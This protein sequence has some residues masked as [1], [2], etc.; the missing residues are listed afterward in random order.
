[1]RELAVTLEKKKA[2][3]FLR[4]GSEARQRELSRLVHEHVA[5]H[6]ADYDVSANDSTELAEVSRRA[7]PDLAVA[8]RQMIDDQRCLIVF[9][10]LDEVPPGLRE[11]VR[12]AVE[13]FCASNAGNR[14]LLTCRIRSYE[15]AACLQTFKTVT[16][17]AFD[18]K[19]VNDFIDHWYDALTQIEHFTAERAGEKKVDLRQAVQRLPQTM[20]RNPLLLTT[21]ANVHANNVEL[22]RQRVKLYQK[23]GDLLLRRWQEEKAG[24]LSLFEELGLQDDLKIYYALW[25]LGY[26]AQKTE[27]SS[28]A[29]DIPEGEAVQI[30]ARNFAVA[31]EPLVAA[32]RFLGFVDQTAGLLIGRGGVAGNV[33]AFPHRTFQEYFAGCYLAK[34]SRDFKRQLLE[35][36]AEGDY[37][38]LSAQLGLEEILHNDRNEGAASDVAYSLCPPAEP[39]LSD[40]TAWR[41]ILWA[42]L[43]ALEIDPS[44]IAEDKI[45]EGGHAFLERLRRRLVTTLEQGL[46]PARERADAGFALGKLGD[47]RPGVCNLPPVWVELPGGRFVMGDKEDGPPHEVELSPFKISKY[48]ITNAQFAE[49]MNAGGYDEKKC[50]ARKG[51][52]IERKRNGSSRV[53]GTTIILIFPINRWLAFR[54]L[55]RKRSA[56]GLRSKKQTANSKGQE[57]NRA[58]PD[59]GGVGVCRAR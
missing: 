46:L 50:G 11:L 21:M 10:G 26:F 54:G 24:K 31:A 37:W 39:N 22:P 18:E 9:D 34:R 33:Y 5:E 16:L 53:G 55:K 14:F 3:G 27:R 19:Q 43:F 32:G 51:G 29:A 57:G 45:P 58:A 30:L 4:Q 49:F 20:V 15:G 13:A 44:R 1:L 52:I 6:L 28:E 23:A 59:G 41:G 38:R 7:A 47:P 36:L 42:A 2:T 17:A 8:L 25:E 56:L 40:A 12:C 48:P 35:L